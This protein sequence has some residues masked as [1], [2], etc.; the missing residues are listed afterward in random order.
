MTDWK[1]VVGLELKK[2]RVGKGWSQQKLCDESGVSRGNIS[3]TELGVVGSP[4][5]WE[6]MA[7]AM[8]WSM[9]IGFHQ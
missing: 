6:R 5:T 2:A 8:G 9:S 7:N 3:H 1:T 4:K